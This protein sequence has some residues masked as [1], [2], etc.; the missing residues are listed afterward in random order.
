MLVLHQD[1]AFR[2]LKKF[3]GGCWW[4]G[5]LQLNIVTVHVLYVSLRLFTLDTKDG[6][7]WGQFVLIQL[8]GNTISTRSEILKT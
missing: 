6:A 3:S 5:G 4:V 8:V 7:H 1:R 2:G